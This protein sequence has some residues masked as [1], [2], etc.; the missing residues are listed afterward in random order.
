MVA[1]GLFDVVAYFSMSVYDFLVEVDF[2]YL[3]FRPQ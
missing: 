1:V 3:D 2:R